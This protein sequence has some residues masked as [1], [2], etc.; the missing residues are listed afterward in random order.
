MFIHSQTFSKKNDIVDLEEVQGDYEEEGDGGSIL[1]GSECDDFDSAFV[2]DFC[3]KLMLIDET[4]AVEEDET[5]L[6]KGATL[7]MT[8]AAFFSNSG[9]KVYSDQLPGLSTDS[10]CGSPFSTLMDG[11]FH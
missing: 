7:I 2:D 5:L 3:E 4:A 6:G 1:D 10:K 9:R 11:G 8:P